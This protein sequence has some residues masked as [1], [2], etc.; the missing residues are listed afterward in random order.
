MNLL[1]G[2]VFC[3]SLG[4][5]RHGVLSELTGKE[6]PYGSLNFPRGNGGPLV[7]EGETGSFDSDT[8]KNVV[9]ERVHDA[10]GFARNTGIGVNLL[11][12]LVNVDSVRFAPL[13]PLFLI[14]FGDRLLGFARLL[15]SFAGRFWSH[16]T[17]VH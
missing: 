11:E 12:D 9:D 4:S 8:F 16:F 5:L 17:A 10:H 15:G 7:V 3:N 6:E 2:G 14:S 1:G 13:L